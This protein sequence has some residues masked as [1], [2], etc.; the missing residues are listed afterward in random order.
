MIVLFTDIHVIP[1]HEAKDLQEVDY[2]FGGL[3]YYFNG[4][5][6]EPIRWQKGAA[7]QVLRLVNDD[8]DLT[9]VK[10]NPGRSYIAV[11]DLDEAE[12]FSYSAAAASGADS[13]AQ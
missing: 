1:G 3:G 4:G 6:V 2:T 10:V 13:A 7:D 9:N 5:R 12:N 8:A 11:V